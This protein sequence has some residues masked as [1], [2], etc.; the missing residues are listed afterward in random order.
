M[1]S[2]WARGMGKMGVGKLGIQENEG[3]V[4]VLLGL[5][6]SI[7]KICHVRSVGPY[8]RYKSG[9]FKPLIYGQQNHGASLG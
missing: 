9:F 5:G 2:L 1:G 4:N 3:H 7:G 6:K 8:D